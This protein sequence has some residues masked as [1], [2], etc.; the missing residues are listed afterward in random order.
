MRIGFAKM[1]ITPPV[2]VELGGYAGYRPCAGCHD[3]LWCKAVVVEQDGQHDAL[4]AMDLL[5]V[6]ESLSEAI[7]RAL[8]PIGIRHTL[9]SAIHSHATPCGIVLGEGPLAEVNRVAETDPEGFSDYTRIL[10]CQAVSACLEAMRKLEGFQ[11]RSAQ[12]PAPLI[13]SERHTGQPAAL[14][15]TAVQVQTESGKNLLLYQIPCHPT[16]LGPE[17]LLASGDFVGGIEKRLRTDMSVFL[18]GAAGDISTRFTRKAQTFLECDRMAE[19]A[20][21]AVE[22]LIANAS[23]APPEPLQGI[24]T[25]IRLSPRPVDSEKN[26]HI[27][28][29]QA[30]ARWQQAADSGAGSGELRILKSY[31]EGAGVALEFART[32]SGIRELHLPV[33]LFRFA[34]LTFVTV[35]GEL[36]SS[37]WKLNAVPICYTNGY[38]RYIADIHAYDAGYYE[39]MAAIVDRGQGEEFINQIA[40][41]LQTIS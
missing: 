25:S 27:A 14:T 16:V 40:A 26:A 31:V 38:Y 13:G 24:H 3:P 4:L 2:G 19:I 29:E 23:Y 22:A 28:L 7:H 8:Q 35:P 37:L 15:M 9:V 6:D 18:N 21:D 32:M 39:A 10:I 30:M 1:P 20:A 33:T 34:G 17:N 36:F 5:S 41:L 11:V 12:G